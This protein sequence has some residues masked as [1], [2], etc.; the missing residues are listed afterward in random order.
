MPASDEATE[1]YRIYLSTA[2]VE[3]ELDDPSGVVEARRRR[4]CRNSERWLAIAC[5]RR[6]FE[7]IFVDVAVVELVVGGGDGR[8]RGESRAVSGIEV[9]ERRVTIYRDRISDDKIIR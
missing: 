2:E 3:T 4:E 5:L 1:R 8:G 6:T 9:P 7:N